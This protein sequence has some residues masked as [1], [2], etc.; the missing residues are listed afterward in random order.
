[1]QKVD[2]I[3][4]PCPFCGSTNIKID[5][6]VSR[7]RCGNCFSAS[8]LI[9]VLAPDPKADNAALMAWNKRFYEETNR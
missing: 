7:V 2:Y 3:I 5:K 9:S 4:K 1:M 6:C 8:G